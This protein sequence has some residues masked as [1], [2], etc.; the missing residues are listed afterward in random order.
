MEEN[1]IG[2]KN[3]KNRTRQGSKKIQDNIQHKAKDKIK[4]LVV[5]LGDKRDEMEITGR[6]VDRKM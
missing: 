2:R 5:M 4:D 6:R 1:G 3:K